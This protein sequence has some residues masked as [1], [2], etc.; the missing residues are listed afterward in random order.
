[1]KKVLLLT[2]ILSA[3]LINAAQ[4]QGPMNAEWFYD[5]HN[6]YHTANALHQERK[7]KEAENEYEKL[8]IANHGNDYDK[9]MA[10]LN[11]AACQMAQR[12]ESS[13]WK[14]FD[15]LITIPSDKRI[16]T[17]LINAAKSKEKKSILIQTHQVG[18]GD[19]FHFLKG[20][21]ELKKRTD[22]NVIISVPNFLKPRIADA[23]QEYDIQLVGARDEQP[24][25][26]HITHII[27]LLGH[28]NIKPIDMAPAKAMFT[29][30]DEASQAVNTHI[31]SFLQKGKTLAVLFLGEDRQATLIGGRQL[32]HDKTHHGRHLSSEAFNTLLKNNPNLTIIDCGSKESR[33]NIDKEY[34]NQYTVLPQENTPFDTTVALAL[35]MNTNEN[36]I[37]FAADQGP[38]NVFARALTKEA[39]RR[40]AFIIP[41]AQNRTGEYDMRMEGNGNQYIQMISNCLV[42][43][44]QNPDEQTAVVAKIYKDLT[45]KQNK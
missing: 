43:K 6:P 31:N 29:S 41:N 39:Q 26:D 11:L 34:T 12:K 2:S 28:L 25:T 16:S 19:I 32:P 44:C 15:E 7:W 33:L 24:K 14:A 38:S 27:G 21:E 35:A 36:I 45:N 3:A 9:K 1:M 5:Q 17:D 37:G 23:A 10:E 13:H 42:Y 40:M 20:A 18:I 30:P 8:L 22:W 4:Q